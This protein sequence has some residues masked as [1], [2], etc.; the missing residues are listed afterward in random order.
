L[1]P[2][3]ATTLPLR[4]TR[5]HS[6]DTATLSPGRRCSSSQ[7]RQP[8]SQPARGSNVIFYAHGCANNTVL[9]R[10]FLP[11]VARA[12]WCTLTLPRRH[13]TVN[14]PILS[15]NKKRRQ[16][17]LHPRHMLQPCPPCPIIRCP[18]ARRQRVLVLCL[19][20]AYIHTYTHTHLC[21][22][23]RAYRLSQSGTDAGPYLSL[24]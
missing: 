13:A 1:C 14:R 8:A 7:Y 3:Q 10:A 20:V 16:G 19:W 21:P 15:P 22:V 17:G 11:M 12:A 6:N 2:G 4:R 23:S 5:P 18:S 9:C 24:I